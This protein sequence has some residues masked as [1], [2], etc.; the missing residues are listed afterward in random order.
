MCENYD[1]CG[2]RYPLPQ[3]GKL[4]ATDESCPDCGA[5][6]VVVTT[7]RGPWRLCPN[8]DCPSKAA[9]AEK[10]AEEEKAKLLEAVAAS[11]K[12]IDEIIEMI[13]Q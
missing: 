4:T 10:K 6:I 2:T 1:D 5:P 8:F 3:N 9:A 13:N 12:S 7:A 11:G